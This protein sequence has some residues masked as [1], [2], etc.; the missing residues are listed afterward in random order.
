MYKQW[1]TKCPRC[2]RVASRQ[3]SVPCGNCGTTTLHTQTAGGEGYTVRCGRGSGWTCPD[4]GA[5]LQGKYIKYEGLSNVPPGFI[6]L[7]TTVLEERWQVYADLE[8]WEAALD[9]ASAL[10][11]IEPDCPIGWIYRASSLAELQRPQEAHATLSTAAEKFPSEGII[12]YDLACVCCGL[13]RLDEAR[14]WLDKAIKVGGDKIK[15]QALD[16]SDLKPIRHDLIPI[17]RCPQPAARPLRSSRPPGVGARKRG[18]LETRSWRLRKHDRPHS[19]NGGVGGVH[20]DGGARNEVPDHGP[21][22]S[23]QQSGPVSAAADDP[24]TCL[25]TSTWSG[26]HSTSSGR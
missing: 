26:Q 20:E 5:T 4:C 12:F 9:V 19:S 25:S 17:S 23:V 21:L 6:L 1:Q 13:E 11:N 8:R 22:V 14:S 16:D 24:Q 18:Q 7:L 15:L 10:V 2:H 3:V